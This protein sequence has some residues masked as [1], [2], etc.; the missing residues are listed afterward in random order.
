MFPAALNNDWASLPHIPSPF[1]FSEINAATLV[2]RR[3]HRFVA[4]ITE[5][6]RWYEK[7]FDEV[8]IGTWRQE[9]KEQ[10]AVLVERLWETK[11]DE[12]D[13]GVYDMYDE[14]VSAYIKHWPRDRVTDAQLDWVFGFLRWAASERDPETGIEMTGIRNV[15]R[16]NALIPAELKDQLIDAVSLLEDRPEEE[17]DWHPG[18]NEQV[19]DLVHPSLYC[20]RIGK[21]PISDP[22]TGQE[23]VPTVEQYLASRPNLRGDYYPELASLQHQWLPTDFKVS[24]NGNVHPL[25][26][27][28]NMHPTRHA[29]LYKAVVAIIGRFVPLWE[30]VLT[31]VVNPSPAAIVPDPET[32]YDGIDRSTE[33]DYVEY[34]VAGKMSEY[35]GVYKEWSNKYQWPTVPEPAPFTPPSR[36]RPQDRAISFR[37]RTI[38]VIVKLANIMLT[39]EKPAYAGGSWHVEGM[40][41][42]CIVATGIYYYASENISESRLAFRTAVD[43]ITELPHEEDDFRGFRVVYGIEGSGGPMNQP[44]G[45]VVTKEDLCLAFPNIYQ[46]RVAPFQLVDPTKPGV[47]KILCFFV[48]D[49]SQHILSTTVQVPPQQREWCDDAIAENERMMNLPFELHDM[50][51]EK[52]IEGTVTLEEAKEERAALMKERAHFVVTH[53]DKIFELEFNMCEH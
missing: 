3:M 15:Y 36:Q 13:V 32:W 31:D 14:D 1:V 50:I 39:P 45:P 53:T 34:M 30:R 19:L 25:G 52:I 17:K 16:S 46:H 44:L 42:E 37:G 48:V 5:K 10:D 27:I 33:P 41:N 12:H 40:R 4:D 47:R 28:N 26:Y 18:S 11:R 43:D 24:N 38:Q 22:T 9:L 29:A 35:D 21:S 6:P 8:V 20:F 23:S 49:P 51:R 7:V 2:E